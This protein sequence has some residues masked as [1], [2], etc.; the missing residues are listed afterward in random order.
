[1]IGLSKPF[2]F[3]AG[4]YEEG[5][6]NGTTIFQWAD[7]YA[8]TQQSETPMDFINWAAYRPSDIGANVRCEPNPVTGYQWYPSTDLSEGLK[9]G[10][11]YPQIKGGQWSNAGC[12]WQ[13]GAFVCKMRLYDI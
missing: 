7:E 12:T 10:A 8:N 4:E 11:I 3:Y 9:C 2:R 13:A 1:W 6:A 5:I